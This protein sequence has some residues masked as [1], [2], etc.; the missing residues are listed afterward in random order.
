[1]YYRS[2]INKIFIGIN[3]YYIL[4]F[5]RLDFRL[6]LFVCFCFFWEVQYFP[7]YIAIRGD[8]EIYLHFFQARVT[9]DRSGRQH[10]LWPLLFSPFSSVGCPSLSLLWSTLWL[11]ILLYQVVIKQWRNRL[12]TTKLSKEIFL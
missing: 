3:I 9:P 2:L 8:R 1:M 11:V 7:H 10:W 5:R 4:S 6:C 12:Q